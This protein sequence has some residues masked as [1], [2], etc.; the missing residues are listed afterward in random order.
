MNSKKKIKVLICDDHAL[1]RQGLRS[2]LEIEKEIHIVGEARNG[3]EAVKLA[4]QEKPDIIL[5]DIR[6][7][8]MGGI[9]ATR[10]I[11]SNSLETKI[12][13]LTVFEDDVHIFNAIQA[14]ANGYFLKARPIKDLIG[15]IKKTLTGEAPLTPDVAGSLIKELH[16][17]DLKGLNSYNISNKEVEVLKKVVLG[18][19]NREI[20]EELHIAIQ[21]VKNHLSSMYRKFDVSNRTSL[22]HKAATSGIINDTET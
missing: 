6:M 10:K 12:L 20:S 7:P 2:L 11:R 9:E 13:V 18:K 5:M 19:T 1:F 14:G 3:E 8:V 15:I 4:Q 21:T 22:V 17:R 16:K